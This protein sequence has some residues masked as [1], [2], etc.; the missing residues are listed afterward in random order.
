MG[1]LDDDTGEEAEVEGLGGLNS[2]LSRSTMVGR[3]EGFELILEMMKRKRR[4]GGENWMKA[5]RATLGFKQDPE[6]GRE[7]GVVQH[8][9]SDDG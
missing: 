5:D 3:R 6:E 1:T 7:S 9:R 8:R 2:F 4:G